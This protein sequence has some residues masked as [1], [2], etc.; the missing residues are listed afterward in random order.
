[1]TSEQLPVSDDLVAFVAASAG[2]S[3][4]VAQRVVD[5]VLAYHRESVEAYVVRRHRELCA[6]GWK[7]PAI[8]EHLRDEVARR[9]FVGPDCSSRQIRRMIYG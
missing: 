7:N 8:Y 2:L 1:M 3:R 6:A 9:L 5:D 4:G